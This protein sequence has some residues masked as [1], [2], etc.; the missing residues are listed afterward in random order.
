MKFQEVLDLLLKEMEE[1]PTRSIEELLKQKAAELNLSE[2][3]IKDIE[4]SSQLIDEFDKT[5]QEMSDARKEGVTRQQFVGEKLEQIAEK[6]PE[7]KRDIL[8]QA[9]EDAGKTMMEE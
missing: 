4:L 9:V 5:A 1:N 2:A 6:A 3:D 7:E 8:I